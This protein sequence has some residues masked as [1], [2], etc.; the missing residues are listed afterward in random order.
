MTNK[1]GVFG[2]IVD[3][4][5][6]VNSGGLISA[7]IVISSKRGPTELK[8]ITS[9]RQF[10]EE[11]GL[12]SS[13]N[14]SM[15]AALRYL[16]RT[17][18]L[19]VRRVINDASTATVSLSDATPE[20][21]LIINASSAGA[22]GNS[23]VVNFVTLNNAPAGVFGV[24]VMENGEQVEL[25]EVSRDSAAKNGFGKAIYIEDVVN[26]RSS[27]IRVTDIPNGAASYTATTATLSG[28]S[29]DTIAP[30][31]TQINAGWDEFANAEAVE[32]T[33]LIN[34][35]WTSVAV[36]Q[37]MDAIARIRG[38]SV[39]LLDVPQDTSDDVDA[40]VEYVTNDLG[41]NS[42]YSAIYGGWLKVQDQYNDREVTIPPSGD[43]A[44]NWVNVIETGE[45]WFA[46]LGVENGNIPNAIDTTLRMSEGERTLLYS[47]GINPITKIGSA[48]AVIFGQKSLQAQ[49]SGMDRLNVVNNVLNIND[50][51]KRSLLP[52]VG[53]ANTALERDNINYTVSSYLEGIKRRGGLTDYAV[54]TSDSINTPD[55]IDDNQ[56]LVD[57]YIQP[58]RTM[59]AINLRLIVTSTGVSLS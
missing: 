24:Q 8:T 15:Y 18:F 52:Y 26:K 51:V 22:W 35:G 58:T 19:T 30:T 49:A 55:V 28:G 17:G 20:V 23:I 4:S 1:V 48:N 38:V 27:Y 57:V 39:A 9:A 59:E 46:A 32:A 45:Y 6:V 34:A 43:V 16:N 31:D 13:D 47:N 11:Y 33:F 12:P 2:S 14:P 41:I 50:K 40:M 21:E 29:D 3:R 5:F 7:G 25:W 44:A 54:D 56:M 42:F 53:R 36:Q 37:K 10:V